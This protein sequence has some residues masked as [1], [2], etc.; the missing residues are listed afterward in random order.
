M[1]K[2]TS[3]DAFMGMAYH[4]I[5]MPPDADQA[6]A[7][8]LRVSSLHVSAPCLDHVCFGLALHSAP[9]RGPAR[10]SCARQDCGLDAEC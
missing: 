8:H 3:G 7:S 1:N 5:P 4:G 6:M 2:T 9:D 10:S